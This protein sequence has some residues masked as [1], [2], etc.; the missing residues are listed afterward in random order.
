MMKKLMSALCLSSMVCAAPAVQAQWQS[1]WLVGISGGWMESSGG[2]NLTLN[3]P[4]V[5]PTPLF[6]FLP[7]SQVSKNLE[8][9]GWDWGLLGGYQARC[10]G[11]LVGLELEVDWMSNGGSTNF[12]FTDSSL[13]SWSGSATYKRETNVGLS[14]RLGY[15]VAPCLL[16]YIRVGIETSRDKVSFDGATTTVAVV[17]VTLVADVSGSRRSYRGVFGIGAEM[18]IPMVCG[19]SLRAEYDYHTNGRSVTAN[20]I[21]TDGTTIVYSSTKQHMNAVIASLIWNFL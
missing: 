14:G 1:N 7:L 9:S 10:N 21:A 18:P 19:L 20:G 15:Q 16:P 4:A 3:N 12:Q 11:W 6:P 5:V 17:P 13:N 2:L 8:H